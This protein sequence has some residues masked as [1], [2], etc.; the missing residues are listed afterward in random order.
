MFIAGF[1][2]GV[3]SDFACLGRPAPAGLFRCF[4][5]CFVGLV[6]GFDL[7][8]CWFCFWFLGFGG[9]GIVFV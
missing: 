5:V 7:L 8:V 6:F 2:G 1:V 9:C 3:L 4:L